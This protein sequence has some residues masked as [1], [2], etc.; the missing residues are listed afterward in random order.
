MPTGP[1]EPEGMATQLDCDDNAVLVSWNASPGAL[2]YTVLAK[3]RKGDLSS[4]Y[5]METTCLLTRLACGQIYNITVLAGDGNCN[6]SSLAYRTVE[7]APCAPVMISHSLVCETNMA[8]V[9]WRKE[10]VAVGYVLNA[11]SVMGHRKGCNANGTFCDLPEL[12]CGKMYMVQGMSLG[13][14]CNSEPSSELTIVTAPCPPVMVKSTYYCSSNIAL[15]SW[16]ESLGRESFLVHVMGGREVYT[17]NTMETTSTFTGLECQQKY[18]VTVR[19]VARHCNSS[20]MAS[21]EFHTGITFSEKLLI[22]VPQLLLMAA[23]PTAPCA[24]QNVSVILLCADNTAEVTWQASPGAASYNVTALARD[25]DSKSCFTT[26]T[27]CQLPRMHCGQM[28][29][30]TVVPNSDTCFGFFST[31]VTYIAGPCPPNNISVALTCEG[32]LGY[33]TWDPVMAAEM[34]TATAT[35]TDGHVQ[36]CKTN[37]T[38]CSFLSLHCGEVYLVTVVTLERGCQSEPSPRKNFRTAIC[39]PSNLRGQ[40]MCVTHGLMVTWDQS[41]RD[42]VTYFLNYQTEDGAIT[43]HVTS[44]ISYQH[45]GLCGERYF[46]KVLAQDDTCNSSWTQSLKMDTGAFPLPPRSPQSLS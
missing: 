28:Y 14:E 24:P 46:F 38:S 45:T 4:C 43:T 27:L 11:T 33:V 32:N 16:D 2:E 15:I 13:K 3:G 10:D 25:G 18:N 34:Y 35:T 22:R 21:T 8:T 1:C 41:P 36:T 9:S 7:T 23:S 42:D 5:T 26:Q 17:Q 39:P 31:A 44:S 29:I 30:I 6:S 20:Q 37:T 12:Q 40:V 19:A